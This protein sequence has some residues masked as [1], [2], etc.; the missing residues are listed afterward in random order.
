MVAV[1]G[2][3]TVAA[4][5]AYFTNTSVLGA[6]TVS[7]GTL[8][9]GTSSNGKGY[10]DL[11]TIAKLEPGAHTDWYTITV[12][13]NGNLNAAV[14]GKFELTEDGGL[15]NAL[16]L[17]DYKV[18]Y[19]K[20]DNSGVARW[21]TNGGY[22]GTLSNE[23]Y[24]IKDN[25]VDHKWSAIGG[26]TDLTDWTNLNGYGPADTPGY[27]WDLEGLK[28]GYYYVIS[29]RLM[30]DPAADNTYQNKYAKLGYR[31]ESTQVDADALGAMST[32][33]GGIPSTTLSSW[34]S[35]LKNQVDTF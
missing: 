7:S 4:T 19:Y 25:D 12:K 18:L 35:Y 13:N 20:A 24:F 28:P 15:A 8:S 14:F 26:K 27:S 2:G 3:V 17:Y 23:D 16:K 22:Y 10:L 29:F 6:N 21:A 31:V 5:R 1:V 33:L 11:G 32:T 9:V 30:M 34:Y